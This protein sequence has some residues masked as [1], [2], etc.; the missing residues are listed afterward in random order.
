MY[1]TLSNTQVCTFFL[2]FYFSLAYSLTVSS[3]LSCFKIHLS[4]D[5]KV[6]RNYTSPTKAP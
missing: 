5:S 2:K 4:L 6:M 1:S 3:V